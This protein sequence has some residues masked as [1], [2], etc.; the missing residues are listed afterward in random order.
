MFYRGGEVEADSLQ[1]T[2]GFVVLRGSKLSP[3]DDHTIP[4]TIKERRKKVQ[5]DENHILQEDSLF[6]SPSYAAMFVTGKSENGLTRWKTLDGKTLKELEAH[7]VQQ[8]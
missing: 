1:T 6:S 2:E 8:D 4:A 7:S 5:L 3:I